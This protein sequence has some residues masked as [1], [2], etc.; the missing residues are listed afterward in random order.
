M[1]LNSIV[2]QTAIRSGLPAWLTDDNNR[3]NIADRLQVFADNIVEQR[4]VDFC[5]N[6]LDPTKDT[7]EQIR[8][9]LENLNG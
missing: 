6:H 2:R 4:L 1:A 7:Q 8:T 5:T 3:I 9:Y